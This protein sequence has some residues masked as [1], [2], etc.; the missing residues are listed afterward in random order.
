MARNG[1]TVWT[2]LCAILNERRETNLPFQPNHHF[3]LATFLDEVAGYHADLTEKLLAIP[4]T[5]SKSPAGRP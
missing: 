3:Q 2:L 1:N 5:P 4:S